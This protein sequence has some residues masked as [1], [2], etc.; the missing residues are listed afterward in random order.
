MGGSGADLEGAEGGKTITRIYY[1][2]NKVYFQQKEKNEQ[3][4]HEI[5]SGLHTEAIL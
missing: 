4:S 1:G 5:T 2:R 3:I